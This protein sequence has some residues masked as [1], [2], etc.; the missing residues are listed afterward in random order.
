MLLV[1]KVQYLKLIKVLL[2]AQSLIKYT[3]TA[4]YMK[5]KYFHFFTS[6]FNYSEQA[7]AIF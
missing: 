6:Y 7:N 5:E 2:H 3:S 4:S 1:I